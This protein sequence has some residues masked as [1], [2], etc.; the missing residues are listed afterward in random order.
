VINIFLESL[1]ISQNEILAPAIKVGFITLFYAL[2]IDLLQ[3]GISYAPTR[4][5][6]TQKSRKAE[7]WK[8]SRIHQK[9]SFILAPVIYT[10]GALLN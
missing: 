3:S 8:Y 9:K 5:M 1:A 7:K 10:L 6:F 2:S 4:R